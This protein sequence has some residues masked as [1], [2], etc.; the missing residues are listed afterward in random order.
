MKR[1]RVSAKPVFSS[2]L[3]KRPVL[4]HTNQSKSERFAKQWNYITKTASMMLFAAVLATGCTK[5][6]MP[7]PTPKRSDLGKEYRIYV[8][9]DHEVQF[10]AKDHSDTIRMSLESTGAL[11]GINNIAFIK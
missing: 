11:Q 2:D 3:I 4:V 1:K 7:Q 8:I 5:A 10:I 6:E 9:D